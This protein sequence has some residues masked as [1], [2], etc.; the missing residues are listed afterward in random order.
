MGGGAEAVFAR[1]NQCPYLTIYSFIFGLF[2]PAKYYLFALHIDD[3]I[4]QLK[5]SGYGIHAGPP[6]ANTGPMTGVPGLSPWCQRVGKSGDNCGRISKARSLRPEGNAGM[7]F[8]GGV[9]SSLFIS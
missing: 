7:G 3:L 1:K 2:I 9:V 5:H 6:T 4:V 8:W